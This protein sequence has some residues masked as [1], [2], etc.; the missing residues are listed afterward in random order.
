M[1]AASLRFR[2]ACRSLALVGACAVVVAACG[3]DDPAADPGTPTP[4]DDGGGGDDGS[5]GLGPDGTAPGDPGPSCGAPTSKKGFLANQSITVGAAKRTYQLFV[6]ETYDG[7]RSFALVFVFHGDGGTGTGIRSSFKALEAE[8]AGDAIVVYPDGEGKTWQINDAAGL[9]KDISFID[10]LAADLGKT[11]C[12]D[13]KRI[14]SVGFSKGAYFTNM[15]GCLS[16]TG[17]R[18]VVAHG[19]GGPFGVTG[20]GTKFDN[21]GKLVCPRPPVA[22]MQVIGQNDGLLGEARKARDHWQRVNGCTATTKAYAPSPCV[23]YTGCAA[24]T[25][26]IYCEVPGLGHDIWTV[27]GPPFDPVGSKVTWAFLKTK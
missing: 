18:A 4:T 16:K 22:A 15:L 7:K 27:Q 23:E 3:D 6:P 10:A 12:T 19:G 1:S 26:E 9:G 17:F 5:T 11:H 25:P 2:Y 21:T 13:P 14:F 8:S 20:S 24:T